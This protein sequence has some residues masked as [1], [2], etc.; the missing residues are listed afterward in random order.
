MIQL[1]R[2]LLIA[3][4][5][6]A[7]AGCAADSA[8]SPGSERA[9]NA[10]DGTYR[11][12]LTREDAEAGPPAY[13]NPPRL[14]WFPWTNTITLDDGV[15]QLS[16]RTAVDSGTDLAG[17]FTVDADLLKI[18]GFDDAGRPFHWDLTFDVT[19]DGDLVLT[20][21]PDMHE[22]DVFVFTT[23]PWERID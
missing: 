23:H 22:D 6:V 21:S 17:E 18:D 1:T 11:Y 10:I 16:W 20:P 8:Q 15:Y 12:T 2:L 4:M 9:S 14:R 13:R 5:S 19:A 3:G 7:V